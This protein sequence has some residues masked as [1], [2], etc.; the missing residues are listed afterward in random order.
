MICFQCGSDIIR[1]LEGDL[2][3]FFIAG[4]GFG[5]QR[6]VA[7]R[8][9]VEKFGHE[10]VGFFDIVSGFDLLFRN[11]FLWAPY[12]Y[13]FFCLLMEMRFLIFVRHDAYLLVF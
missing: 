6:D 2:D 13:G 8:T 3:T 10:I 1:L 11:R 7:C 5:K 12:T 4:T 9:P